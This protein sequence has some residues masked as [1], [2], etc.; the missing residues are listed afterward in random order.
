M[1]SFIEKEKISQLTAQMLLEV[2]AVNFN[3]KNPYR[4]TSGL[5][6][7]VYIDCRKLISFPHVRTTLIDF[8][9]SVLFEEVGFEKIKSVVGG[10]TAGIPFAAWISEKLNLPM[11]YVRK[12][13]KGFGINNQIEGCLQKGDRVLLVEDLATDGGSKIKFC[14]TLR[15]AGAIIEDTLVIFYY[16]IFTETKK[17]MTANGIKL[18]FLATWWDVLKICKKEN[19]FSKDTLAEVEEFL[20]SPYSWS[21]K[22]GGRDISLTPNDLHTDVQN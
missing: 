21:G 4:L 6:S 9:L 12:K 10:E 2:E 19:Y 8:S 5:V 13:P 11:Q 7:P 16:D 14:N 18:H 22:N 20:F 17:L 3:S 1:N 15:E